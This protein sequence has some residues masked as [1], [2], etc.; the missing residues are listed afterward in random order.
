MSE[1]NIYAVTLT[2]NKIFILCDLALSKDADMKDV[3]KHCEYCYDFS[4][5]Y[6]PVSAIVIDTIRTYEEYN[7]ESWMSFF[8]ETEIS[9]GYNLPDLSRQLLAKELLKVD[10]HVKQYMLDYGIDN[11]RGGSYTDEVLDI[12]SDSALYAELNV[13]DIVYLKNKNLMSDVEK[14]INKLDGDD[15]IKNK[16]EYLEKRLK[17]YENIKEKHNQLYFLEN[18]YPINSYIVSCIQWLKNKI[19]TKKRENYYEERMKYG[20]CL[21]YF[22]ELV[23]KNTILNSSIL[24]DS[25]LIDHLN[26]PSVIFDKYITN[27]YDLY[28]N[29]SDDKNN[30]ILDEE[31]ILQYEK[32][33]NNN[34]E[35]DTN[36]DS[37]EIQKEIL[38]ETCDSETIHLSNEDKYALELC[39]E[40]EKLYVNLKNRIDEYAFDLSTFP[41]HFE[42][43]MKIVMYHYNK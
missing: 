6:K 1:V 30:N 5:I 31:E 36:S 9:D 28:E 24:N 13:I 2:N 40:Y 10:Y 4:K 19:I 41:E 34:I 18:N 37:K 8:D 17:K 15:S 12:D 11:V 22:K 42:E 38:N 25:S 35:I 26:N 16:K 43:E 21:I 14:I 33:P 20:D 29:I 27:E 7:R 32:E 23:N 39:E 3:M